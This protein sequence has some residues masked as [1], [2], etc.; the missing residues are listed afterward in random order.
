M[1]VAPTSR[2]LRLLGSWAIAAPKSFE[3]FLACQIFIKISSL[4][5]DPWD[6]ITILS[7]V[8]LFAI[9]L[10]FLFP[11]MSLL[12]DHDMAEERFGKFGIDPI[13]A[14]LQKGEVGFRHLLMIQDQKGQHQ[15]GGAFNW[16]HFHSLFMVGWFRKTCWS[17]GPRGDRG[18]FD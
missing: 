3:G 9:S 8:F 7:P 2:L 17:Q 14:F 11:Q 18:Q 6:E 1:W 12:A 13:W 10:F 16:I 5:S 4:Y 15:A